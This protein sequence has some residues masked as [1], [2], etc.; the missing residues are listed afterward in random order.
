MKVESAVK[1]YCC[2]VLCHAQIPVRPE[3]MTY[4]ESVYCDPLPSPEDAALA[5]RADFAVHTSG[6][7]HPEQGSH[8]KALRVLPRQQP[9]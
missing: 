4:K 8:V 1:L 2:A 6:R 9:L 3:T 7:P 5:P